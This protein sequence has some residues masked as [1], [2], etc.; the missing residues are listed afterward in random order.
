MDL[1]LLLLS[2][3]DGIYENSV[4]YSKKKLWY[5]AVTKTKHFVVGTF[6]LR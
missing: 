5:F 6:L 1:I 3:G 4:T 2:M